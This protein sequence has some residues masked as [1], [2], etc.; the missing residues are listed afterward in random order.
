[1]NIVMIVLVLGAMA[2]AVFGGKKEK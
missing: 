1:M 2:V